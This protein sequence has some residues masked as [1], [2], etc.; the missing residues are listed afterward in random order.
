MI[1]VKLFEDN[2]PSHP[3][4]EDTENYK[5]DRLEVEKKSVFQKPR[6]NQAENKENSVGQNQLVFEKFIKLAH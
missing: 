4:S 2:T 5:L 6:S 3:V 1:L